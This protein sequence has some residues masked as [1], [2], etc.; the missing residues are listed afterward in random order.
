VWAPSELERTLAFWIEFAE[1][2]TNMAEHAVTARESAR[3]LER[4]G[5]C[6]SRAQGVR[7]RIAKAGREEDQ[8]DGNSTDTM[9]S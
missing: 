7:E 6:L 4:A 2:W 3:C 5:V 1:I 8:S 9:V